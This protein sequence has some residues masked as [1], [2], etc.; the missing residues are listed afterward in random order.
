MAV[1]QVVAEALKQ[2]AHDGKITCTK[3]R[4]LAERLQVSPLVIGRACD[5]LKIKIIAC[6]LGCF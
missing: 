4:Q 3:A 2:E 5:E 1:D 6:E